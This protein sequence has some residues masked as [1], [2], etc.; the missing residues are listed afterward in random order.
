[1]KYVIRVEFSVDET[2]LQQLLCQDPSQYELF[3]LDA[4]VARALSLRRTEL[5]DVAHWRVANL[6][7]L[8]DRR[9]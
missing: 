3:E 5:L 7:V 6:E 1:M 4:L 2:A 8:R 9:E